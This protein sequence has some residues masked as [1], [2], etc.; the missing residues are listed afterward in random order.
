MLLSRD[1]VAENW[2]MC[3]CVLRNSDSAVYISFLFPRTWSR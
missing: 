2:L 1:F 3:F